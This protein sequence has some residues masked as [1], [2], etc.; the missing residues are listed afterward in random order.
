M[1]NEAQRTT[2]RRNQPFRERKKLRVRAAYLQKLS[3]GE[4]EQE[5]QRLKKVRRFVSDWCQCVGNCMTDLA[6]RR[7]WRDHPVC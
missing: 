7:A 3:D 6:F 4:I 5:S 1:M 2:I